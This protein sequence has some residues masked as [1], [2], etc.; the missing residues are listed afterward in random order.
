MDK[1]ISALHASSYV[2]YICLDVGTIE[3]FKGDA[4]SIYAKDK[5][6]FSSFDDFIIK[7][8][9]Y[10]D[11]NGPQSFQDKR[12]L[13]KVKTRSIYKLPKRNDYAQTMLENIIK[14]KEVFVLCMISRRNTEW[15]G[16]LYMGKTNVLQFTNILD[17]T[18]YFASRS[19]GQQLQLK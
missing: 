2:Y 16:V 13:T 4:F 3:T 5:I 1:K 14:Y 7:M 8:D 17:L 11:I 6:S 15:Q 18:S 12:S 19:H 10:M 9:K